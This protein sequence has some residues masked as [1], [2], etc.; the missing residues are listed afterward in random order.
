MTTRDAI[1]RPREAEV[2]A[3]L[4]QI[5]VLVEQAQKYIQDD[6]RITG[7]DKD[8]ILDR[9]LRIRSLSL[10]IDHLLRRLPNTLSSGRSRA[11]IL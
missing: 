9:T 7:L 2:M 6:G 8:E 5:L 1:D 4:E 10:E 11:S 3:L